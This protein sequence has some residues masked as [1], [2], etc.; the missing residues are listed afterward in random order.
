MGRTDKRNQSW[1]Y[2][3]SIY[4]FDSSVGSLYF[5]QSQKKIFNDH[6]HIISAL[7]QLQLHV[8]SCIYIYVTRFVE[9]TNLMSN[10]ETLFQSLQL[11]DHVV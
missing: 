2:K 5:A 7:H 8:L 11:Q 1:S 10:I 6:S 3:G 9:M 4:K